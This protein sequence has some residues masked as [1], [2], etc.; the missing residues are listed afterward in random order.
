[1]MRG[2]GSPT[3]TENAPPS[4]A[5]D[6]PALPLQFGYSGRTTEIPNLGTP[7]ELGYKLRVLL[8]SERQRPRSQ[9]PLREAGVSGHAT[10]CCASQ[11]LQLPKAYTHCDSIRW[12]PNSLSLYLST[13]AGQGHDCHCGTPRTA[14]LVPLNSGL[15][16]SHFTIPGRDMSAA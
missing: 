4:T 10:A 9:L 13:S 3:K 11:I 1:M 6:D 2:W 5:W 12:H 7:H 14:D 15:Q 16:I 8:G